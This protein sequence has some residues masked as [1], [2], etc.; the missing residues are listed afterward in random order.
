M[1]AVNEF[2][3]EYY[4]KKVTRTEDLE[5]DA[6]CVADYDLSLLG[7]ITAEVKEKRYGC[8]S[9]IPQLLEGL[10]VLDLGSGAGIDCFIAAQLVG[11][12]GRVIGV[13][14]TAEQ[15]EIARRNVAPIMENI[16]FDE[17]N[18]EFLEGRIEEIPVESGT[19]D[20]VIS[21]CVINLSDN[22]ERVF[23]EIRRVLKPGGEFYISDIVADR[24]IPA[25]LQEDTT[26]WSECLS[27]AAYNGDLTRIM[28][29]AGFEDVRAV[30]RRP[31]STVIEGI[32]FEAVNLRGFKMEL[33]DACEDYGQVAIYRGTIDG[34]EDAFTLDLGHVFVS[35]QAVRVC[36]NT[37]D[38]LS[39]SRYASHF[40]VSPE[41]HHV[42]LF[43]DCGADPGDG[44]ESSASASLQGSC[45]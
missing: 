31:L 38:M 4:G 3:S 41:L 15:L 19:V 14:M 10:T 5:F 27:G 9:P 37:A 8:G 18:V 25:R 29:R 42:G 26:L 40:T 1:A 36:K 16:G 28:R 35:G 20:V 7:P 6:C 33:E 44:E 13:D 11:P 39:Q 32:R 30:S 43:P 12:Q 45:C 24:R 17:P 22:K 2:V 34:Y 23:S 21:N